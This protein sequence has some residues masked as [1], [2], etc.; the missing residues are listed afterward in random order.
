MKER[1]PW[2]KFAGAVDVNVR[3]IRKLH[4]ELEPLHVALHGEA[5]ADFKPPQKART[6]KVLTPPPPHVH[7]CEFF[8]KNVEEHCSF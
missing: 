4:K 7:R 3:S 2:F 8:A 5:S 1:G 6:Q